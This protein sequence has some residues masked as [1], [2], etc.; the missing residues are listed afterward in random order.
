MPKNTEDIPTVGQLCHEL[1]YT[2]TVEGARK[3]DLTESTKAWRLHYVSA[4]GTPGADIRFWNPDNG[5]QD[6]I[7]MAAEFLKNGYGAK[8]WPPLSGRQLE[9]PRDEQK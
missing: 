1:G 4:E 2:G 3:Y 5:N 9:Y 6:L 8:H 7:T